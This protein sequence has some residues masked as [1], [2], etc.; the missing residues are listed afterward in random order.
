MPRQ[1]LH[2][3]LVA[4]VVHVHGGGHLDGNAPV[5]A[6]VQCGVDHPRGALSQFLHL[7]EEGGWIGLHDG[8]RSFGCALQRIPRRHVGGWSVDMEGKHV[9]NL[10]WMSCNVLLADLRCLQDGLPGVGKA[11]EASRCVWVRLH[12][13][14]MPDVERLR[15]PRVVGALGDGFLAHRLRWQ[16][17][18]HHVRQILGLHLFAR[19]TLWHRLRPHI[20]EALEGS[21]HRVPLYVHDALDVQ[22]L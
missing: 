5:L 22:N 8:C 20:R 17:G 6:L 12:M 7:G 11:P 1:R 2:G 3:N 21:R 13:V 18:R 16:F 14:L 4:E 9:Q 19:H 10:L 15:D